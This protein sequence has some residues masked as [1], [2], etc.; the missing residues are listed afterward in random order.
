MP[1]T[2][3]EAEKVLSQQAE[4]IKA[5]K[6]AMEST[7]SEAEF[8]KLQKRLDEISKKFEE[9]HQNYGALTKLETGDVHRCF[10]CA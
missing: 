3:D 4:E 8:A 9:L 7:K 5:I 6:S 1:L 10:W 2:L